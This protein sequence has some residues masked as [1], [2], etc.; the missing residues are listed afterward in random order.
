MFV[1]DYS[2][3]SEAA[4]MVNKAHDSTHWVCTKPNRLRG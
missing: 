3:F 4:L 2:S 1:T